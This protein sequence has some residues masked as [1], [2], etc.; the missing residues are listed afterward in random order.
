MSERSDNSL[1]LAEELRGTALKNLGRPAEGHRST[2]TGKPI[3]KRIEN[4]KVAR[5][6]HHLSF[7]I[8]GA[9]LRV[10]LAVP[11]QTSVFGHRKVEAWSVDEDGR[12]MVLHWTKSSGS[13]HHDVHPLPVAMELEQVAS[14]V[15]AW[16][17]TV[18]YGPEPDTDGSTGKSSRVYCEHWGQID[19]H[20]WSSFV[21]IEPEW[22][23]YGK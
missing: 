2:I 19:G 17:A 20:G 15:E 18:D 12:R 1:R 13:S 10:A 14:F 8:T 4:R 21:A 16:L 5:T 6:A 22:L 3:G 11:F 23:V 9:P 7:D